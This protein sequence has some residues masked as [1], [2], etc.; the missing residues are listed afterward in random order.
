MAKRWWRTLRRLDRG[1]TSSAERRRPGA[2][3]AASS[4]APLGPS[5]PDDVSIR[6]AAAHRWR[7]SLVERPAGLPCL[8]SPGDGLGACGDGFLGG[9]AEA[10]YLSGAALAARVRRDLS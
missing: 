5:A 1:P 9:R 4:D 2:S 10:A 6:Y 3:C 7:Y 8:W